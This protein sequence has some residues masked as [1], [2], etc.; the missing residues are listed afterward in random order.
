MI[1]HQKRI[2]VCLVCVFFSFYVLFTFF[3]D[4]DGLEKVMGKLA[5]NIYRFQNVRSSLLVPI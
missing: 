1:D 2:R 5:W 4:I 3:L